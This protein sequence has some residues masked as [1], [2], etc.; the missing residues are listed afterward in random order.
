MS[1]LKSALVSYV[2]PAGAAL[3]MAFGCSKTESEMH[4][5]NHTFALCTSA[6]CVPLPGDATKTI[7]FCDVEEGPS[8][9]TV[10]CDRLRP[11]QDAK[12]IRT[13]FSTFSFKQFTQGK[14]GMR[15]AA[16]TPWSWCLNKRCTV[17]PTDPKRAIC[18][19]DV[20]RT[21]EWMTLGG[22]CDTSTCETGYWSGAAMTD[23]AQGNSFLAKA[24]GLAEPLVKWCPGSGS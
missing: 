5:C 24:L 8:M 19:C 10:R 12:G 17:D 11:S 3:L 21:E 13:V 23:F 7:C 22:N 15:C 18:T 14:Q 9:S 4:V 16:G 20:V 1:R 6:L 2:L